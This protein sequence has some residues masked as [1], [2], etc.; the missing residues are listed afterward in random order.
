MVFLIS[1]INPQ[2]TIEI[3]KSSFLRTFNTFF[4]V[5]ILVKVAVI[6]VEMFH[7]IL[8]IIFMGLYSFRRSPTLNNL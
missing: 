8:D 4:I 7:A 2:T 3:P 6:I 5:S 1:D